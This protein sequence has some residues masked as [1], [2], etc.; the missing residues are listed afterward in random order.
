M[1][2]FP[3]QDRIFEKPLSD[4]AWTELRE[5]ARWTKILAIVGWTAL[6]VMGLV[7]VMFLLSG[8][9]A[10]LLS[11]A[12]IS[13]QILS[14]FLASAIVLG[15]YWYPT[16]MLHRFSRR[17]KMAVEKV[18]AALLLSA[19]RDLKRFFKFVALIVL[20]FIFLYLLVV[21]LNVFLAFR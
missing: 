5:T 17:M 6:A 11:G 20:I 18:D 9:L 19:L 16:L 1:N 2:Q 4:A 12:D 15:T 10:G 14:G 7:F 8:S 3:E 21:L 13:T